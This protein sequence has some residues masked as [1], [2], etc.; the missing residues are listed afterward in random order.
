MDILQLIALRLPNHGLKRLLHLTIEELLAAECDLNVV[1]SLLLR[2]A[3]CRC[4]LPV[5]VHLELLGQ[6][7]DPFLELREEVLFELLDDIRPQLHLI[8]QRRRVV[9][10]LLGEVLVPLSQSVQL[11]F[12]HIL[13]P[14]GHSNQV[15]LDRRFFFNDG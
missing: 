8:L 3:H 10:H 5:L 12:G 7:T 9:F 11:L 13:A 15:A 1:D 6:L 2:D 4:N 14:F